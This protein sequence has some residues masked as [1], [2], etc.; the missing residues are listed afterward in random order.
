M[1]SPIVRKDSLIP[2]KTSRL[3]L[4]APHIAASARPGNFVILRVDE[5]GE[6]IPLTIADTDPEA[7]TITIVY[8]VLGKTTA[9]LEQLKEGDCILD[10][11]GPLGKNTDIRR[12]GTVVCV[13]GGTG[14]AAMHHI[15][16]G[17]HAAGNHVVAIIGARNKD[18][19]LYKDELS[20]FCPEV[21]ISSDDGS[22]GFQGLV[23]EVLSQRLKKDKA[24]REVVAIGPVPMMAAC[25]ET[26]KPFNVPITVSL[27]SIMVDG[28]GMCGACRVRVGEETKFTCVDG[29]EFD[30]YLV[31]FPR[32]RQRLAA[33]RDQEKRSYEDYCECLE[34]AQ[35][36]R[37]PKKAVAKRVDMPCQPPKTR[38]LNFREVALGYSPGMALEEARRC[39][40]CKKPL[41]VKG[42]PVEVPIKDFIKQLAEGRLRKAYSVIKRTN[43]LPAVC[44]RVCPQEIQCEGKCVLNAKGQPIAIGRL[45]R[46]VADAYLASSACQYLIGN[47][48]CNLTNPDLKVACIGSG[49]SSLTVAGYLAAKGVAVTV[50]EALHEL[51]GVLVYGIPEFRLPKNE[52]VG[53]EINMLRQVGVQFVTNQVAG[54]TFQIKDLFDDGFRSV[55]IGVGA[56][57]PKFLGIPGENFTGVFSANE[58]L[59]RANL[60]R[61]YDFPNYDTPIFPGK[62]VTVYGGGNVAMDAARTALRLGAR[63]VK[64]VYR[65]TRAELPARLEEVEHAEEEGIKFE[66]LSAPV[67]FM[68]NQEGRLTAVELQRMELGPPDDSGRQRPVP[69]KDSTYALQTDLA[70]IAVG[71][72]ANPIL[73]EST[74]GLTLNKWGYIKVDEHGE[75]TIPNVFAGGD[76]VSGAATVILAM[77]AGRVA[78]KEMGRRLGLAD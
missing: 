69:I 78:A 68:G 28:I 3:V 10:L 35:D 39:L 34:K 11:C 55:F 38:V 65:R 50:F 24:V 16:K 54:K 64:I 27:N 26:A 12:V 71:T 37:K 52:I 47:D 2:G 13:G 58:Y 76:I 29:P 75:T 19:L 59:T 32:L 43:S 22:I 48:K 60:G 45:E 61:A 63:S 25:V 36:A 30:G 41:C 15:A 33:F 62:R 57:L 4:H 49:P 72:G 53:T 20:A 17:H 23:T 77:G 5:N 18:L 56:G 44:G 73:L 21:L 8:L 66:L 14:I 70:I 42:C 9:R 67:R 46:F 7:G 31:D 6:R 1:S 40:Q 74:P 51:G